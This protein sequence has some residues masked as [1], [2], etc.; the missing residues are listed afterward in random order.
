MLTAA[1]STIAKTW[2][3]PKCPSA[4]GWIEMRCIVMDY[5]SAIKKDEIMPFTAT[6]MDLESIILSGISQRKTNTI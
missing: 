6:Q 2:R 3:H 5:Y 1:L 4:R